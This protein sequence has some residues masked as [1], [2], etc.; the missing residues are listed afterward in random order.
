MR[1][2]FSNAIR[3]VGPVTMLEILFFRF[4][5]WIGGGWDIHWAPSYVIAAARRSPPTA[6]L[7]L[8]GSCYIL[9][10]YKGSQHS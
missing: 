2:L 7:N 5:G 3:V 6:C 10:H 8:V 9:N 4:W 1:R